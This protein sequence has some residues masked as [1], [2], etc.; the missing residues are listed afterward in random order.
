MAQYTSPRQYAVPIAM[1]LSA[2]YVIVTGLSIN[3]SGAD[4]WVT[5]EY[6]P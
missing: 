4:D 2:G 1:A 6:V 5:I 3:N